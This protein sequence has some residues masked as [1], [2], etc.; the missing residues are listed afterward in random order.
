M[1]YTNATRRTRATAREAAIAAR[2]A[3]LDEARANLRDLNS[4]FDAAQQLVTVDSWLDSQLADLHARAE[5]RRAKCRAKAGAV[6][7]DMRDRGL[8]V[9]E[10][11]RMSGMPEETL[12]GYTDEAS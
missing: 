4:F 7:A 10:I 9:G 5:V 11:A 6:L 1:A 12:R 8:T 2:R 3:K